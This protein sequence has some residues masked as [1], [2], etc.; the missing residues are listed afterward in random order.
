MT[1]MDQKSEDSYYRRR[2]A[3]NVAEARAKRRSGGNVKVDTKEEQ[4]IKNCERSRLWRAK[5]RE[6]WLEY[7]REYYRKNKAKIQAK[8]MERYWEDPEKS[9]MMMRNYN[10]KY[11][12]AAKEK[13]KNQRQMVVKR[14]AAGGSGILGFIRRRLFGRKGRVNKSH[15]YGWRAEL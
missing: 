4:R 2:C 9:R 5:N 11:R 13:A 6:R 14:K 10:R 8:A 3:E 1:A 15:V 12:A 7:R